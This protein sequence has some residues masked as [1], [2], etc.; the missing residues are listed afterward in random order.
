MAYCSGY[1]MAPTC[2][3]KPKPKPRKAVCKFE[4]YIDECNR[5]KKREIRDSTF[6]YN[7]ERFVASPD[8]NFNPQHC[9]SPIEEEEISLPYYTANYEPSDVFPDTQHPC[10]Q[11]YNLGKHSCT[12]ERYTIECPF[13]APLVRRVPPHVHPDSLAAK[14]INP[15]PAKFGVLR[16][17]EGV[18][19]DPRIKCVQIRNPQAVRSN[20]VEESDKRREIPR[21][22]R[23]GRS[24][25]L[26]LLGGDHQKQWELQASPAAQWLFRWATVMVIA[27]YLKG[28]E[29]VLLGGFS[30]MKQNVFLPSQATLHIMTMDQITM[31]HAKRPGLPAHTSLDIMTREQIAM[32]QIVTTPLAISTVR[33]GQSKIISMV[34]HQQECFREIRIAEGFKIE[35]I[36]RPNSRKPTF[37]N[38]VSVKMWDCGSEYDDADMYEYA[39]CPEDL[40]VAEDCPLPS[41]DI[42]CPPLA[43]PT[44]T[45]N[46]DTCDE[47]SE[48]PEEATSKP[49]MCGDALR[50]VNEI[51]GTITPFTLL[52]EFMVNVAEHTADKGE[53]MFDLMSNE[54][55]ELLKTEQKSIK[56]KYERWTKEIQRKTDEA[57]ERLI[58]NV[59]GFDMK[60]FNEDPNNY[61][62]KMILGDEKPPEASGTA[63]RELIIGQH[64]KTWLLREAE[65][66]ECQN[67][68]RMCRLNEMMAHLAHLSECLATNNKKLA[69]YN[70]QLES[71]ATCLRNKLAYNEKR[72]ACM[73]DEIEAVKR[74]EKVHCPIIE[75]D[76]ILT[77]YPQGYDYC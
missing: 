76:D 19:P 15:G 5:Q 70:R 68:E 65:R 3:R 67:E 58:K 60:A 50:Q 13:Y 30:R 56:N 35:G 48:F 34:G 2:G 61:V 51:I 72:I 43:C 52:D 26:D 45:D 27:L 7:L 39:K 29:Q 63:G 20:L 10:V 69:A 73:V 21:P 28:A 31:M 71:H 64:K 32:M 16:M 40:G 22:N 4:K 77:A 12:A 37:L 47:G 41:P 33:G 46:D 74:E 59:P 55:S 36:Y 1:S 11:D 24:I 49:I 57:M 53:I 66:I 14:R 62:K 38:H 75:P 9:S 25:S 6:N 17:P 8:G 54:V 42:T 18:R 44:L 23:G